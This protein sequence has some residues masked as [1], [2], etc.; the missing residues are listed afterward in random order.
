MFYLEE[1][2]SRLYKNRLFFKAKKCTL[3]THEMKYLGFIIMKQG[4][5]A[6][7]SKIDVI[8]NFETPKSASEARAFLGLV[9][10]YRR[11]I[12]NCSE[13]TRP[14]NELLKKDI[15]YYW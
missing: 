14:I 6:G 5:K 12:P 7:L 9:Q 1:I 11:F 4:L 13:I 8:K 10:F 3:V 15:D 2:F